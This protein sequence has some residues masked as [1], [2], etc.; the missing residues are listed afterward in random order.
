MMK[1]S[2]LEAHSPPGSQPLAALDFAQSLPEIGP[3]TTRL[4]L[5]VV[6]KSRLVDDADTDTDEA[7][8]ERIRAEVRGLGVTLLVV[9]PDAVR[10]FESND[11]YRC[12]KSADGLVPRQVATL[13]RTFAVVPPGVTAGGLVA[14]FVLGPQFEIRFAFRGAPDGAADGRS[15]Q[16]RGVL[17]RAL[18]EA[19]TAFEMLR[20][21]HIPLIELTTRALV[22]GLEHALTPTDLSAASSA[23]ASAA[24]GDRVHQDSAPLFGAPNRWGETTSAPVRRKTDPAILRRRLAHVTGTRLDADG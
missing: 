12:L 1:S 5:L 15:H 14:A 22:M 9:A 19:S 20:L 13:H 7:D 10:I 11:R 18:V 17:L 3:E 21:P 24:A 8:V 23:N 16:V 2:T 6:F 4:P